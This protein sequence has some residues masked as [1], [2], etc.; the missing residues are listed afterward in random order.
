MLYLIS[1]VLLLLALASLIS[2]LIGWL[3]RAF[4]S[5]RRESSLKKRLHQSQRSVPSMQRALASAHYEIDRRE[6]DIHRLRRKI[7][8]IDSDPGNF[9]PGDFDNLN[10]MH[11]DERA[12]DLVRDRATSGNSQFRGSDFDN[13]IP[14]TEEQQRQAVELLNTRI[15]D[16]DGKYRDSDFPDGHPVTDAEHAQA[17]KFDEQRTEPQIHYRDGDFVHGEP[18][19]AEEQHYADHIVQLREENKAEKQAAREH[20]RILVLEL[21]KANAALAEAEQQVSDLNGQIGAAGDERVVGLEEALAN[22]HAI[23]DTQEQHIEDLNGQITALDNDPQNFRAGDLDNLDARGA[24]ARAADLH[25]ARATSGNTAFRMSDF[26]SGAPL[27]EEEKLRA[28]EFINTRDED[29]DGKY[30]DGDFANGVPETAAEKR[31]G[32]EI[33]AMRQEIEKV[34]RESDFEGGKPSNEEE[35]KLAAKI[36]VLRA[37][38]KS[39]RKL[40]KQRRRG[41][42]EQ[43]KS[44]QDQIAEA[45][46]EI[47]RLQQQINAGPSAETVGDLQKAL[48]EAND[49]IGQRESRIGDLETQIEEI[50]TDP[51]HFRAG[52][53]DNLNGQS[54]VE[55]AMELAVAR[56]TSGN[57][58]FRGSD[59]NGRIPLTDHEKKLAIE[60]LAERDEDTDGKYRGSDFAGGIPQTAAQ[61]QQ[62]ASLAG[63]RTEPEKHYRDG[64]FEGDKPQSESEIKLAARLDAMREKNKAY[65]SAAKKQRKVLKQDLANAREEQ[66][67]AK[68]AAAE[69]E[70][71]LNGVSNTNDKLEDIIASLKQ[72]LSGQTALQNQAGRKADDLALEID[73]LE[74]ELTRAKHDGHKKAG[75]LESELRRLR[76]QLTAAQKDAEVSKQQVNSTE[77]LLAERTAEREKLQDQIAQHKTDLALANSNLNERKQEVVRLTAEKDR[78]IQELQFELK[79]QKDNNARL[80][81]DLANLKSQLQAAIN[82]D[83]DRAAREALEIQKA[84]TE[85]RVNELEAALRD[86]ST[87]KNQTWEELKKELEG[88]TVSLQRKDDD[89][90]NTR[91]QLESL[92]DN[93]HEYRENDGELRNRIEVLET[94][95]TEQRRLTGKSMTSRIREIEAMLAAERRK[96]ESLSIESSINEVS[97]YSSSTPRHIVTT[98]RFGKKS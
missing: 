69:L 76:D 52:D 90:R 94:L 81:Q 56:A 42:V 67:N 55:R 64:D 28:I 59:F 86:H 48:N 11:P 68:Q 20:R 57:S 9:R 1:Q 6:N 98:A 62:A 70:S 26:A 95:L 38:N 96:V 37:K 66:R 16:T 60:F 91:G 58:Q 53:M 63:M 15:E 8:E 54:A 84:A 36:D 82:D 17:D 89:L 35:I 10:G 78:E 32:A 2:G 49:V 41:L 12:H 27:T 73:K 7:A 39:K 61:M 75:D 46:A 44:S 87:A 97:T 50:D 18:R 88:L 45:K 80:Q 3:L 74:R 19:N 34:Y 23:I 25:M 14:V 77:V 13:G 51:N 72:D 65:R 47:D 71:R 93:L 40:A 43:L 24:D 30:R 79:N 83:G 5:E 85:A 31:L 92:Q 22:A 29:T 21:D 33:D 4:Q